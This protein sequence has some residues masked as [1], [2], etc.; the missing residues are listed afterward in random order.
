MLLK[1]GVYYNPHK[2]IRKILPD[3]DNI[4]INELAEEVVITSCGDGT[5]SRDSMHY[6][7]PSQAVDLRLPERKLELIKLKI[8]SILDKWAQQ[9]KI[10]YLLLEESN[11]LHIQVKE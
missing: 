1:Q 3:I 9:F 7:Q 11:H 6:L 2:F 8:Q 4:F 5:H 10:K